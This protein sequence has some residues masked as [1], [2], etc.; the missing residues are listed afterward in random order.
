MFHWSLRD[1]HIL[2][3]DEEELDLVRQ[4][5]GNKGTD[6]I[7]YHC[8][9]K[10]RRNYEKRISAFLAAAWREN[11]SSFHRTYVFRSFYGEQAQLM[12]PAILNAYGRL[13]KHATFGSYSQFSPLDEMPEKILYHATKEPYHVTLLG[14]GPWPWSQPAVTGRICFP[15]RSIEKLAGTVDNFFIAT[16][17]FHMK[18]HREYVRI[19]L[20]DA[21]PTTELS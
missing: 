1:V 10:T 20:L 15:A 9:R 18:F 8:C 6:L 3:T 14:H 17:S 13:T 5:A 7:D 2:L 16:N 11:Q 4:L 12:F 19:S 21:G